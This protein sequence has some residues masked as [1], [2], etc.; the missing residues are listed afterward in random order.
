M[1][2]SR[3][4]Q[5][6]SVF[7]LLPAA[8][9]TPSLCQVVDG[10]GKPRASQGRTVPWCNTTCTSSSIGLISGGSWVDGRVNCYACSCSTTFE[11]TCVLH[12]TTLHRKSDMFVRYSS[13]VTG[14][15]CVSSSM[16]WHSSSY[17]QHSCIKIHLFYLL[18]H[19]WSMNRNVWQ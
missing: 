15:A 9:G 1:S 3:Q 16:A 13:R 11:A 8:I 4:H 19:V 18:L 5:Y 2:R 14:W 12:W 17:L 6:L 7:V 10:L